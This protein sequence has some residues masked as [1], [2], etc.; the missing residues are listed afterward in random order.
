MGRDGGKH[1]IVDRHVMSESARMM[2]CNAMYHHPSPKKP[3]TQIA[4]LRPVP[5]SRFIIFAS[6]FHPPSSAL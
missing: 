3:V 1:S 5:D 4:G 2:Q 6:R